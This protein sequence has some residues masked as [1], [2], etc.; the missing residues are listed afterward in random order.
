MTERPVAFRNLQTCADCGGA[1]RDQDFN[2][3]DNGDNAAGIPP[4]DCRSRRPTPAPEDH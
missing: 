1:C 3:P 2:D 4:C